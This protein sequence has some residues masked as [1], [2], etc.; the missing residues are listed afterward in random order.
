MKNKSPAWIGSPAFDLLLLAN[1]GWPLLL[2]PGF[3]TRSETA[4]DFWQVYYLTLPHRWV[5]L[6]LVAID[7]DRRIQRGW[8]LASMAIV[9]AF[10]V[11]SMYLGTGALLCLGVVDY[12]WNGWH[13]ASQHSG[14]LRIYSRKTPSGIEFL[15]RWGIRAFIFYVIARTSS[16]LIWKF[17]SYPAAN[18]ICM[19]IDWAMLSLPI[20]LLL[21]NLIG[22]QKD[23]L[24]KLVYLISVLVLYSAYMLSSHFHWSRMFFCLATAAA[25]FHAVEY[26][27][28]VSHYASRRESVGSDGMMRSIAARWNLVLT[29]F[30]LSVGTFGVWASS[31]TNGFSEVWQGLNLWAAFTH[32]A[33][34]GVIWK[35]RRVETARAL[36]AA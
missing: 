24:P 31:P 11:L 30:V 26:L 1:V 15:E 23:R 36:G 22:W 28:I 19:L 8:L 4:V 21:T 32:Y 20:A 16:A 3:S 12:F 9:F 18:T 25:L 7:P 33:M 6:F 10:L 17:E 14:V 29:V 13:F 5:T 27:A 35:L 34:D 2:L